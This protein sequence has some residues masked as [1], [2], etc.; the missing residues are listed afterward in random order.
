[1]IVLFPEEKEKKMV[2]HVVSKAGHKVALS[3]WDSLVAALVTNLCSLIT[4]CLLLGLGVCKLYFLPAS[5]LLGCT[6]WRKTLA[7]LTSTGPG[8]PQIIF[9]IMQ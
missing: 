1:M 5:F 8:D 2:G 3:T 9:L 4:G 6:I 7:S